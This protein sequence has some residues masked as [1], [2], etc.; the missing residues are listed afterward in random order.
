LL[1]LLGRACL[2][3]ALGGF[4]AMSTSLTMRL[5]DAGGAKS[6][7]GYLWRGVDCAGDCRA[8]G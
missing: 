8:V 5:A 6:A 7:V 1:L 2:G 4:W 3:L